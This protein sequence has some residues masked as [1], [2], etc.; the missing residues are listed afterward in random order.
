VPRNKLL[1]TQ[2]PGHRELRQV[3][4]LPLQSHCS[5]LSHNGLRATHSIFL[6]HFLTCN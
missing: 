3:H 5:D 1:A 6:V 2:R 4:T